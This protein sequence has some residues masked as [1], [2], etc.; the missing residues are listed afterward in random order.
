MNKQQL[1]VISGAVLLLFSLFFFGRT[2]PHPGAVSVP[3]QANRATESVDIA[4][5]VEH[6]KSELTPAQQAKLT[7][8]ENSIVR[9]DLQTQKSRLY[10]ELALFWRD[11]ARQDLLYCYY[12]GEKAKLEN[13]EKSLTF[14]ANLFLQELKS[15]DQP[16][17]RSW[18]ALQA[19]DLFQKAL[20][21]NPNNDSSQIGLGST[22]FFGAAGGGSP[23]EGIQRI[24]AVAERDSL[25]LYAQFMLAYGGVLS[26]QFDKAIER[27]LRVLK[28]DPTNSEAVFLLAEAY[29]QK[30]DAPNAIRWYEEGKKF[31]TRPE[32][33]HEIET[34]I[35]SLKK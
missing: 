14:A 15:S 26:G 23:M 9:G 17:L 11:S 19:K 22:Y 28:A 20:E 31:V 16:E 6:A 1:I 21:K 12:S 18:M 33:L 8:M 24:R 5:F 13:S 7:Q 29:E 2:K 34:R 32:V 25:N 27:L 30:G 4:A 35:N 3:T 10:D